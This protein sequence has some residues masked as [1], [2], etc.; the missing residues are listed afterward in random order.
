[1]PWTAVYDQFGQGYRE[2]RKFRRDFLKRLTQ[3]T[4]AYPAARLSSNGRGL[5]LEASPPPILKRLVQVGGLSSERPP[6]LE[7][8]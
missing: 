8:R 7:V 4:A 2:V 1:V 6:Q 5:T 3:V